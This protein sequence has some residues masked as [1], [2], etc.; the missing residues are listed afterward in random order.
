MSTTK[1]SA[2]S[3][4]TAASCCWLLLSS[5]C[6]SPAPQT[7]ETKRP[8]P[9]WLALHVRE[10]RSQAPL[11]GAQLFRSR[12]KDWQQLGADVDATYARLG[13]AGSAGSFLGLSREEALPDQPG[14]DGLPP[15][16]PCDETPVTTS[17]G[18]GL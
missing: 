5:G 1:S 10:A 3:L 9:P 8:A 13:I 14:T 6:A 12:A 4:W 7:G 18:D 16:A 2:V 15:F 11:A 17:D